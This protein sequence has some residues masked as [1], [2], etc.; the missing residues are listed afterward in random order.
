MQSGTTGINTVRAYSMTK[1]GRDQDPDGDYIRTW[2]P[3][4]RDVPTKHIHEPWK[5]DLDQQNEFNCIIGKTYPEPILDEVQSRKEGVRKTYAA[6]KSPQA[7]DQSKA[8]YKKHGSRSRP[9]NRRSPKKEKSV[10][11]TLF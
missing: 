4:L 3:E 5:M 7:R 9:R 2:V 8:V 11:K 10:Q 6:R 1:Q